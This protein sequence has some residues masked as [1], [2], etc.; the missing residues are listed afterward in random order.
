MNKV[1]RWLFVAALL[2]VSCVGFW[3]TAAAEDPVSAPK[4]A[5]AE[6]WR[7]L[8]AAS[9]ASD[10]GDVVGH[11][12]AVDSAMALDST[13]PDAVVQK[14]QYLLEAADTSGAMS[15]LEST[16]EAHPRA[17]RVSILL[18][19]L[20]LARSEIDRASQIVDAVLMIKPEQIS[21]LKIKADIKLAQG[22]TL[23]ALDMLENA[24]RIG[25]EDQRR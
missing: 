9:V 11:L 22:D 7:L 6:I 2:V 15:M 14:A 12:A 10:S 25:L 23:S 1:T 21:A 4:S 13:N 20:N 18:A 16:L 17:T 3:L 8:R 5:R 24:L 19:K